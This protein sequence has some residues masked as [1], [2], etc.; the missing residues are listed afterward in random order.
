MTNHIAISLLNSESK[1]L[2]KTV[3]KH[4][5]IHLHTNNLLSSF[6]SCFIPGGSTVTQ[7]TYIYHTFSEALS[8]SK[9]IRAVFC[10][11]SN[12]FDRVCHI[13]RLYKLKAAG[14]TEEVR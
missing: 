6:Q 9:E 13:G 4:L 1:R 8:S 5:C 10:D 12:A 3:F 2:D 14:V 7:L 11:T